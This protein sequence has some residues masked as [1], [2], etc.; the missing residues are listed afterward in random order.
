M[1]GAWITILK[2]STERRALPMEAIDHGKQ[3]SQYFSLWV[4]ERRRRCHKKMARAIW[5]EPAIVVG[6]DWTD[7][8]L[9]CC[10]YVVDGISGCCAGESCGEDYRDHAVTEDDGTVRMQRVVPLPQALSPEAKAWL[11]RPLTTDANVPQ[12]IEQRRAGLDVSQTRHRD[13]LLKMFPVTVKDSMVAG[14]PVREVVP[15]TIKH[16]DRVLICLHG[17][18]FNADSGSYSESIAVA[19]LTGVRVVSVLY[20]LAQ[21]HPFPAGVEDVIAVYKELLKT[22]K[23]SRI[24]ISGSS[25][26]AGITLQAAVKMK[27]LKMPMPAALGPFSAPASMAGGGG[28]RALD[29]TDGLRG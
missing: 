8:A 16:K 26:G 29:N 2:F 6:G 10:G 27:Q 9:C 19:G 7:D 24:G 5:M 12:T 14:M 1:G 3:T 20:R 21:E 11:S 4:G 13:E 18:G 28:S 25:A 22:Y 17:G 23:P 15:T